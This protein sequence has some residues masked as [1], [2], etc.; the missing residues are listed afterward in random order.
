MPSLAKHAFQSLAKHCHA[1]LSLAKPCQA[2]LSIAKP[3]QAFL[4]IVK[5]CYALLG[6]ATPWVTHGDRHA[7]KIAVPRP[8]MQWTTFWHWL[9][10]TRSE[11]SHFPFLLVDFTP[12]SR[13]PAKCAMT[14][15]WIHSGTRSVPLCSHAILMAHFAGEREFLVGV[16]SPVR[17]TSE[18]PKTH[19]TRP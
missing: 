18:D 10:R 2:F 8:G 19:N 5:P 6:P 1:L 3:C 4:S 11:V 17:V 16:K 13:R 7:R 9:S 15:P 14:S 12:I